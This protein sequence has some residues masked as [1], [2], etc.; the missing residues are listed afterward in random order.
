MGWFDDSQHF[1]V[2][3]ITYVLNLHFV[4][5][6]RIMPLLHFLMEYA[7]F[8][9]P[10]EFIP[11]TATVNGIFRFTLSDPTRAGQYRQTIFISQ[12]WRH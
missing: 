3:K 8:R 4:I 6:S 12:K 1:S 5:R 11:W 2:N 10:A 7:I 9:E